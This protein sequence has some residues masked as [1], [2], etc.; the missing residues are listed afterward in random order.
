MCF[1]RNT[2]TTQKKLKSFV[3]LP[4]Y[5]ITLPHYSDLICCKSKKNHLC[6]FKLFF[7]NDSVFEQTEDELV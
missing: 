5:V 3:E 1:A 4:Y 7:L 2:E 6:S